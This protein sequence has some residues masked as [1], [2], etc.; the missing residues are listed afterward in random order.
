[1]QDSGYELPRIPL[2]STWVNKGQKREAPQ[3]LVSLLARVSYICASLDTL[4]QKD[5]AGIL[6]PP[7]LTPGRG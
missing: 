2:L 3:L 4:T 6:C 1:M 5:L 7:T